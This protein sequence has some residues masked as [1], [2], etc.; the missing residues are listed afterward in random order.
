MPDQLPRDGCTW[1]ISR[2]AWLLSAP[3]RELAGCRQLQI[4]SVFIAVIPMPE[5]VFPP[6]RAICIMA[7]GA[8][9]NNVADIPNTPG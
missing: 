1:Q 7:F 6:K 5:G 8:Q 3:V 4:H 9:F 2:D